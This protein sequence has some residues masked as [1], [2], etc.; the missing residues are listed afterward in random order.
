MH[1]KHKRWLIANIHHNWKYKWNTCVSVIFMFRLKVAFTPTNII[2]VIIVT[3]IA[4]YEDGFWNFF[5]LYLQRQKRLHFISLKQRANTFSSCLY[6]FNDTF[7]KLYLSFSHRLHT[8]YSLK[9]WA[10]STSHDIAT[11]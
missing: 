2:L 5:P 10:L 11:H 7:Q 9:S 1:G 6:V 8:F 3:N 4:I